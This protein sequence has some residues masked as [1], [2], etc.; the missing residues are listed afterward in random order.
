M[1]NLFE[2][3][4]A[5]IPRPQQ[6]K[7]LAGDYTPRSTWQR[8]EFRGGQDWALAADRRT[9][10]RL[11]R[12][13]KPTPSTSPEAY[14][15]RLFENG[16]AVRATARAGARHA[17]ATLDQLQILATDGPV[18]QVEIHD[19][20]DLTIRGMHLD[21]KYIMHNVEYLH[22]WLDSLAAFKINTLLIEYEDKFP[23]R[24]YPFLRHPDAFSESQL[25]EFLAHARRLGLR[26]IPLIQTFGHVEFILKHEV[27]AALRV[28]DFYTE[29]N[30]QHPQVWPLIRDLVDEIL[31]YHQADEWFHIGGDECWSLLTEK[32][33][34]RAR[35]YG[36]HMGRVLRYVIRQGKRPL[37]WNDMLESTI[38]QSPRSKQRLLQAIPRQTIISGYCGYSGPKHPAI[39]AR[40][41]GLRND[42][43]GIRGKWALFRQ[44]GYDMFGLPCNNWGAITPYLPIHT[45]ANTIELIREAVDMTGWESLTP[46]GRSFTARCPC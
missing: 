30:V 27:F 9:A 35:L 24:K 34:R 23:Y 19:W 32:P 31:E 3:P 39:P 8:F 12:Q 5:L 11:V 26:I 7:F 2:R 43:G 15:L 18:P 16:V 1:S 45:V 37:M 13:L 44:A 29:Y 38:T 21:L 22:T 33:A 14:Q 28:N 42:P 10:V 20:P 36:Q 41:A 25:R 4:L 46:N 6:I 40:G 17:Q